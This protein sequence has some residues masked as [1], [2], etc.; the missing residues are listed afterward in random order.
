MK[1]AIAFTNLGPYHLARLRALGR[2]LTSDGDELVVHEMAS[3]ERKYPWSTSRFDEPFTLKTLFP[4][5]AIE[6]VSSSACASAMTRALHQDGPDA[7]AVVG[8]SRPESMAALRWAERRVRP[9][10]LLSESQECDA[11]RVWW[12]EAV[13]RSRVRRFTSALV[14]GP[15]HRSYLARLGMPPHRVAL[16]YNAIDHEGYA[17]RAGELRRKGRE[18]VP[19]RE[20]FLSV[21][22]F[23]PEKNLIRL[24]HAYALYRSDADPARAWDLVLCGGGPLGSEIDGLT[25]RLGL[26]DVVHRPGFLQEVAL[27]PFYAFASG[28]VLPSRSEPWGLVANEAA[29][30]SLPLL[31]SDR[32]GC[33]ETLVPDLPGET[34]WRFDPD[35]VEGMAGAMASLAGLDKGERDAIGRRAEVVA[36]AWGAERFAAGMI[37]ALAMAEG[38]SARATLEAVR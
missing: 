27:A 35:D 33:A 3:A 12:K 1:L 36:S 6:D 20:Y 9:A 26:D 28:F 34:G 19:S 22:R 15:R 18:S 2:R 4:S 8:Y 21:S 25:T 32:C 23:A 31:V 29:A 37:E 5:R 10:I 16:G 11:P 7:V 14:G 38:E 13:K 30:S 24:I 17:R